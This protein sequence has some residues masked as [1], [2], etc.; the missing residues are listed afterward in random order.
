MEC[1]SLDVLDGR[2][3]V[4]AS[5]PAPSLLSPPRCY[6]DVVRAVF[7]VFA[8]N[9]VCCTTPGTPPVVD[10]PVVACTTPSVVESCA[11]ASIFSDASCDAGSHV[12]ESDECTLPRSVC[13][14][15][16]WAAYF[17][18]GTCVNGTCELVTKY[19]YCETGCSGGACYSTGP[20]FPGRGF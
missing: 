1:A 11:D 4:N 7:V 17:D 18:N 3:S 12:P 15:S 20:T 9:L 16:H 2:L 5:A 8:S 10:P 19:Y 14:D 6:A 13:A